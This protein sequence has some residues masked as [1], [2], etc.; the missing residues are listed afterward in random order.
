MTVSWDSFAA[1]PRLIPPMDNDFDVY[2]EPGR[3]RAWAL[4][5]H[6]L[7]VQGVPGCAHGLYLMSQCPVNPGG[8]CVPGSDHTD[9]WVDAGEPWRPFIL[10]S[11]Y[12]DEIPDRMAAY[13]AAHGL[14]AEVNFGLGKIDP[15][16]Y[17]DEPII[18][19]QW[20]GHDSLPIRL[21]AGNTGFVA[22]PLATAAAAMLRAY[23]V[24]WPDDI[25]VVA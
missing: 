4:A 12:K 3:A 10:T 15:A 2:G 20:Y 21:T 17:P 14:E 11:P 7:L 19:D 1:S 25:E 6:Y 16:D 5:N 9:I 8:N 18:Y 24:H 13:A 23:P 22:W